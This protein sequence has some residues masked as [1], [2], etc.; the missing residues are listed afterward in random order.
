M[1]RRSQLVAKPKGVSKMVASPTLVEGGRRGETPPR[2]LACELPFP[3]KTC[4]SPGRTGSPAR[5]RWDQQGCR[6]QAAYHMHPQLMVKEADAFLQGRLQ[7]RGVAW[8]MG[9]GRARSALTLG[10]P[11]DQERG[12][13][14]KTPSPPT[15]ECSLR[16]RGPCSSDGAVTS[17]QITSK[18]SQAGHPK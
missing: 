14:C 10:S 4:M 8:E 9:R 15:Q 16:T 13:R 7:H 2:D 5:G 12:I 17:G 3:L 18:G 1:N 11:S 6:R